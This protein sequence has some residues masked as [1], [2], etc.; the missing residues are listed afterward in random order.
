MSA[1]PSLSP[2][3]NHSFSNSPPNALKHTNNPSTSQFGAAPATIAKTEQMIKLTLNAIFR[4]MISAV[5]PQNSAPANMP[6]Y[7]AMVRPLG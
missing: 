7:A 6:T 2:L 3:H 4:P 5:I 1:E